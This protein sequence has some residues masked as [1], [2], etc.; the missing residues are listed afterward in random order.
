NTLSSE[1]WHPGCVEPGNRDVSTRVI[2]LGQAK[3]FEHLP[4]PPLIRGPSI[5]GLEERDTQVMIVQRYMQP[6]AVHR[7][8][9]ERLL[10]TDD[11]GRWFVWIGEP[12]AGP[13]G[14]PVTLASYLLTRE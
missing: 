12:D 5:T 7:V 9:P 8:H 1:R 2:F 11:D 13:I 14:I 6:V 10:L 4:A 3:G